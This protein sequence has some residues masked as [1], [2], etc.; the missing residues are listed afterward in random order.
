[1]RSGLCRR[2]SAVTIT[3]ALALV[4]A[5]CGGGSDSSDDADRNLD[6]GPQGDAAWDDLVAAAQEEG[7]VTIYSSQGLDQL[8]DLAARFQGEYG[9]TVTVVRDI[10]SALETKLDAEDTTGNHVADVVAVADGNWAEDKGGQGWFET[11]SGP[12]FD[13]PAYDA[14]SNLSADGHFVS[15]AAVL[16]FG[17]NTSL[18]PEGLD[19]YDDLLDPA[20]AGGKIGV[21]E[22]GSPSVVDFYTNYLA[23][24]FGDDFLEELAAQEPRL[25]PSSLPM[26]QALASGEISAA[27]F[28]QV[29]T[30]EKEAGAPVE[31]GLSDTVWGARFE[32]AVLADA[33]H[34]KAAQLLANYMITPS[35]QEAIARKS[36]AVLPDVEG[37]VTTIDKVAI[38]DLGVVTP[39]AV[40]DFQAT[41]QDLFH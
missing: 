28:V 37:T 9:I 18:Y 23:G 39:E 4:A 34:P 13:E 41:W 30:D 22:P 31:S 20:L 11:P 17:W 21:M 14:A 5:A 3:L 1:M 25:Y 27:A 2:V 8:N 24:K 19:D 15:S 33:P 6:A 29:M 10:D 32:T 40:T 7:S 35:G 16:T 38:I 12:A 36:A 26:A